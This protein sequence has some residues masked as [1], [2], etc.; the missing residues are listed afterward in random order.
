MSDLKQ[1]LTDVLSGKLKPDD[2]LIAIDEYLA[3]PGANINALRSVVDAAEHLGLDAD[4]AKKAREKISAAGADRTEMTGS[5]PSE[6]ADRTV[7]TT[8]GQTTK[9]RIDNPEQDRTVN[10]GTQPPKDD[11]DESTVQ[12]K[13]VDPDATV[14]VSDPDATIQVT[15]DDA[16]VQADDDPFAMTA[17]PDPPKGGDE[18]GPGSVLKG[19]F[20]LEQVIGQGGMGA[21]YKA[22][23]LLKVEARDRNPYIA[24]KLLVGDFKEH[25]E[26]FIALQRESA[27]AQRLAH[28]N[29]ATVYDFDR[30][31]ETVYMTMELMIGA[32][33][34]K[35]IKKLPVGG[36]PV[37]E[38]NRIIEQ[39]CAG[40]QYAHA[41]GLVHSDFKPGNAF[42]LEDGT[43]KL[44]DF[45]I[46]RA[47][48]TKGDAEGESTVFDPGQLGALTPA[49]ATIEMFEG[50]DPDPRDD[51]YALACVSY[52]LYT[53]K[54]PFNKMSAVKAK[55]KGLKPAPVAKLTKRQ[56]RALLKGLALNRDD[57]IASV[58]EFWEGLRPR[59]DY[60]WQIAGGAIAGVLLISL[61]VWPQVQNFLHEREHAAIVLEI[62]SGEE[63]RLA[64]A[65]EKIDLLPDDRQ[66]IV[67]GRAQ[68]AIVA[69][70]EN[71]AEALVDESQG[72]YNFPGAIAEIDALGQYMPDSATVSNLRGSFVQ[73]R[74]QLVTNL[75]ESFRQ[76]LE[77]DRILPN[78]D[79]EDIT[80]VV[81]KLRQ[82]DPGHV[83]LDNLSLSQRYEALAA[84]AVRAS[85]W[86]RAN[87]ILEVGLAYAP[88][89][90]TL[91]DL[92]FRVSAEL[93]RQQE[94]S[95]VAGLRDQLRSAAP[96][97]LADF[98]G[99]RDEFRQLSEVRPDD[100]LVRTLEPRLRRGVESELESAANAQDWA[101][102]DAVLADFATVLPMDYLI[103]ARANLTRQ[104]VAAGYDTRTDGQRTA[105]LLQRTAALRTLLAD[106]AFDDAFSRALTSQFKDLTARLTSD[107][108][109]W[110]AVRREIAMS[111][112]GHARELIAENS[113]GVAGLALE[114][115]RPFHTE[116]PEFAE[117]S[118]TLAVAESAFRA[119]QARLA[120][121]ETIRNAKGRVLDFA[122][123]GDVAAAEREL[124]ALRA[125]L[126]ADDPFITTEGPQAIGQAYVRLATQAGEAEEFQRASQFATAGLRF[127]PNSA[128]LQ[129][130]VARY[131]N[132]GLRAEVT[133]LV[134]NVR[135]NNFPAFQR[136]YNEVRQALPA[137][138]A[139]AFQ[140]EVVRALSARLTAL[141][142]AGE[143][144]AANEVKLLALQLF[145]GNQTIT[146]TRVQE[147]EQPFRAMAGID[148]AIEA[149]R[150]TEARRLLT[151]GLRAQPNHSEAQ[152]ITARIQARENEA[153]A[154][155]VRF[156]T[157]RNAN[158]TNTAQQLIRQAQA[159]WADN[160]QFIADARSVQ[161]QGPQDDG[162]GGVL[163][164]S[165]LAGLGT[166]GRATCYSVIDGRRGP[167]MVVIPAPQG[168]A[169]FAIGK[170]EL[171]VG[172]F[173]NFC[174]A[175]GQC[176]PQGGD[177]A[178][179]VTGITI[180]TAEAYLSWLSESTGKRYRLPTDAEWVHAANAAGN[181]G[182]SADNNCRVV[183]G[184]N[185]IKGHSLLRVNTGSDNAWGVRNHIG[186]AQE[187]TRAG[188]T[189]MARGGAFSDALS[190]CDVG[191]SR[192]H[193]GAADEAT[194][195]RIARDLD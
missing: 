124:N 13:H 132:L 123:R 172:E 61:L 153:N 134:A 29:I 155:H 148:A 94:A 40:L 4:T 39:L 146:N 31:G 14:Q 169:G 25:P 174:R 91:L 42:L 49:Y 96:Q 50:M 46:A 171:A 44:L 55:E 85:N 93:R 52:E 67:V 138:D 108:A 117:V 53:G 2:F 81:A 64:G 72:R 164:T 105:D 170:Y 3:K 182:S 24:V 12:I 87:D 128:E 158:D 89:A 143:L 28:P 33:L 183:Q 11:D 56:N 106:P 63:A 7:L 71:R 77:E 8:S 48:K 59:K 187:W 156:R 119:E 88:N 19:R 84:E 168:G 113:F 165:T 139:A 189:L 70:F 82:A 32:E 109:E 115:G 101:R 1:T 159:I 37:V 27:K 66:R 26:A 21:V 43:V 30:D 173:N 23:D 95:L 186:N 152:G 184:G 133:G 51:L 100:E 107:T 68:E 79:A 35:Y 136:R 151:E 97:T 160:E 65:L 69:Y 179:P 78:P 34:A 60:T 18:K 194:S 102:A 83:L 147:P 140:T 180:Q 54:H 125:D 98:R 190:S 111:Y 62:D 73:R 120:A 41:R 22:V 76:L 181:P 191:L 90:P 92:N 141:D 137:A 38:A 150:L 74:D 131:R 16:T 163:C 176:Q 57:R 178:M 193:S 9:L 188:G 167:T 75:D 58:E 118:D 130:L 122:T 177:T 192:P 114:Q 104:Q 36:L 17:L 5:D 145:P 149:G 121:L 116:L 6:D 135:Q 20:R 154:I 129:E 195:F 45:G 110:E 10:L 112:I 166:S 15:G 142:R 161:P 157:A 47:S 126:P 144:T 175:T 185:I 162:Q 103:S 99:V 80:D 127:L 86:Q